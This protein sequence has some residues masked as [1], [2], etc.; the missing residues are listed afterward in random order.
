MGIMFSEP[1]AVC[2]LL[3]SS[4]VPVFMFLYVA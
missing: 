3:D 4:G 1:G 2:L